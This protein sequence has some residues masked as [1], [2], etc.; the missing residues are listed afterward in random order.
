MA[1]AQKAPPA[2]PVQDAIIV[3]KIYPAKHGHHGGAWKVA[4]ADFMTAMMMFFM[5]MWLL[6]ADEEIKKAIESYFKDPG[7]MSPMGSFQAPTKGGEQILPFDHRTPAGGRAM[8]MPSGKINAATEADDEFKK[9]MDKLEETISVELG[10]TGM[11]KRPEMTYD[12]V[13]LLLR[14]SMKG[15]FSHLET[16]PQDDMKPVINRIGEILS[17]SSRLIRIEGHTDISEVDPPGYTSEWELSAARAGWIANYWLKSFSN[18]TADR[19]QVAGNSHHRPIADSNTEE[20]RAANRRVDIVI[21]NSTY[22]E[23]P[24]Q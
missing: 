17:K 18:L 14:I 16:V 2:P 21:L 4:Y 15:F 3:K 7:S 22:N 8:D 5:V 13:G 19:V 1:E 20:G 9:I 10:M 11:S 12:S 24:T 23:K 6:G